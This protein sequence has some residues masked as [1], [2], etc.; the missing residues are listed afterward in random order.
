MIGARARKIWVVS[1]E[2]DCPG[3]LDTMTPIAT[4][5]AGLLTSPPLAELPDAELLRRFVADRDGRAF[6]VLVARH[7]PMVHGVCRRVLRDD[8]RTDDAFQAAFLV[9]VRKAAT[10]SDPAAVGAWLHG[11]ACWVARAARRSDRLRRERTV[12]NLPD[13]PTDPAPEPDGEFAGV[14]DDELR[15]L[16]AKYQAVLVACDLEGRPRRPVAEALGIPEGTLSSRLT[17]A[18]KLLAAR[19]TRRGIVP[20][21]AAGVAVNGPVVSARVVPRALLATTIRLGSGATGAVPA[22]VSMLANGVALTMPI[23]A[24]VPMSLFLLAA[25]AALGLAAG[26]SPNNPPAPVH[27]LTDG[28]KGG[29]PAPRAT[30]RPEVP[31]PN[32]L[33]FSR[34][35]RLVLIAPDG[36]NET[37]VATDEPLHAFSNNARLSP[38]GKRLALLPVSKVK[39][40]LVTSLHVRGLDE[41]APVTDLGVDATMIAWSADGTEI[42]CTQIKGKE[43]DASAYQVTHFIVNVGTKK[44]TALDIPTDHLLTDWS[45][46][47]K[48]FLTMSV[49]KD[50][51]FFIQLHRWSRDGKEHKTLAGTK[52]ELALHGQFSPDGSRVLHFWCPRPEDG[53]VLE[54]STLR[55]RVLD[56]ATGKAEPVAGP[57]ERAE[58]RGFCW[59][60]DGKRIAYTW[61]EVHRGK[62]EDLRNKETLSHLVVC[63]PDGKNAKTIASEKGPNPWANTIEE[64][65]WR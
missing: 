19:L 1:A 61:R 42:A 18:R 51:P 7:G 9:L 52:R 63:D 21:V 13:V 59:S 17:T 58:I 25:L 39:N 24:L 2:A 31:G 30:P 64:V 47:G 65:S 46:D 54:D 37:R 62:K 27:P 11:V 55:L 20:A 35:G 34:S 5:F 33:L 56:L 38:D 43:N 60:P 48:Y 26:S 4:R 53:T 57:S 44:T 32:K 10:I 41:K 50:D 22:A 3:M 28:P 45:R 16:P 23:R 36:K 40:R 49:T 6:A 15:K 12:E 14:L 8:H 29:A